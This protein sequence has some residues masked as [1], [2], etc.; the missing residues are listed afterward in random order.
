M[1]EHTFISVI[2]VSL[3][4]SFLIVFLLLLSPFIARNYAAKWKYW[5]WMIL[6]A[7]LVLPWN[8]SDMQYILGKV[9][10][11]QAFGSM[12]AE[13][14]IQPTGPAVV[15]AP[16]RI[17]LTIPS[18]M[19]EPLVKETDNLSAPSVTLLGIL[20]ILW[21]AGSLV[22]ISIHLCSYLL[23]KQQ[24]RKNGRRVKDLYV[25]RHL[26]RICE[27]LHI[28]K[29]VPVIEYAKADS[30][31]VFG[32]FC[33]VL[34]LPKEEYSDEELYFILKHEL[35]HLMR[36]DVCWKLLLVLANA[37]H[38][39]N[40]AV[41]V[42]CR[43]ADIDI[44]LSCD[45]RV[46]E[47]A[48]I[49][50]KK[51]YTET[52]FAIFQGN[53]SRGVFLSTQFDGGKKVMKKRF[54]NILKSAKKRNGAV[55]LVCAVTLMTA[56]GLLLGCTVS[57]SDFHDTDSTGIVMETIT[58]QGIVLEE[59]KELVS[60]WYTLARENFADYNYVNWRIKSLE[61][62]Y[63][64]EEIDGMSL[65]VY[66]LNYEFLSD[67]PESVALF[68]GGANV[69]EDGW[70]TPEYANSTFL[71]F[72]NDNGIL[73]FL[74]EM[75]ENDC[76]PGD[77]TFTADLVQALEGMGVLQTSAETGGDEASDTTTLI[78]MV[79]GETEEQAA[80]LYAGDGYSIYVPDEDWALYQPD[81]WQSAYNEE[82]QFWVT[83]YEER[84]MEEVRQELTESEAM[85]A[86]NEM[87]DKVEMAKQEGNMI[88]RV[89]LYESAGD[90]WGVF[91]RYPEEAT[92]GAGSRL[93]VIVDTFAV[94]ATD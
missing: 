76:F 86:D 31:M 23:Y 25:L 46:V 37:F 47:G 38:W 63:T 20:E 4:T 40:P 79:E 7:R 26:H 48:D 2:S 9:W 44:E 75:F 64:Y 28:R 8:I 41:W 91:Y 84:S 15:T 83:R 61:H 69:T 33:P 90:V 24:I 80:S 3:T 81:S 27:E 45:E 35:I 82:I 6:A 62:R 55:L 11:G 88:L 87:T 77:E 42:M 51:A 94:S 57:E 1:L 68:A 43:E 12:R 56:M 72:R 59:A 78:F 10:D 71:V 70:V 52:L 22:F 85:N 66:Q 14:E 18:R 36:R 74:T 34:I 17:V 19:T 53:H 21:L 5:V 58:A 93:P 16:Q 54:R 50:V 30:P 32:I 13:E 67:T 73:S 92:E 49:S 60:Q 29:N 89:R 39:F 65:E